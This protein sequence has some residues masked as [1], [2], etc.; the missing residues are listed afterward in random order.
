M[1][2]TLGELK[3]WVINCIHIYYPLVDLFGK[4]EHFI[5]P[6]VNLMTQQVH[7][8]TL[9]DD[10]TAVHYDGTIH[11][12][13]K[14]PRL[15]LLLLLPRHTHPNT[16]ASLSPTSS[17]C[18]KDM[19]SPRGFAL[20]GLHTLLS[21]ELLWHNS[22]SLNPSSA[23]FSGSHKLIQSPLPMRGRDFLFFLLPFPLLLLLSVYLSF[24][25][26]GGIEMTDRKAK[27]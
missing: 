27:E 8:Q 10:A 21:W 6:R 17:H 16:L 1:T 11:A 4:S 25:S 3:E 7:R 20:W 5:F 19:F 15:L 23:Q 9:G 24:V 14:P 13:N 12:H 18:R 2:K 26:V 22:C